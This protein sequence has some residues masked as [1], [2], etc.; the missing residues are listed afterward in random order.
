M[1]FNIKMRGVVPKVVVGGA[2]L[3]HLGDWDP[4]CGVFPK[5][6]KILDSLRAKLRAR[7]QV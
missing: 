7:T 3:K 5:A 1:F 4:I 2:F 6:E